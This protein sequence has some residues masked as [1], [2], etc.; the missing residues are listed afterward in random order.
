MIQ[1]SHKDLGGR[2]RNSTSSVVTHY[3]HYFHID[4]HYH[5]H[6]LFS[7]SPTPPLSPPYLTSPSI[8]YH[9]LAS[10][11]RLFHYLTL[12]KPPLFITISS[13]IITWK[14]ITTLPFITIPSY[15]HHKRQIPSIPRL[16]ININ[17]IITIT[18]ITISP[19]ILSTPPR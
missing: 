4:H 17:P 1:C 8:T 18:I 3:P 6:Y 15:H 10:P 19:P 13:H 2:M 14:T 9:L 12:S 5:R 7:L 16:T 11:L